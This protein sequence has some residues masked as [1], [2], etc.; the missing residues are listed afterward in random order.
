MGVQAHFPACGEL[1]RIPVLDLGLLTDERRSSSDPYAAKTR[2]AD[3]LESLVGYSLTEFLLHNDVRKLNRCQECREFYVSR[4][5]RPSKFCSPKC[6]LGFHNRK[7]IE[8]GEHREY[9]RKKRERGA[10]PSYYG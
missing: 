7:R 10:K 4:T 8:S 5:V 9:K 1:K 2:F 3:T 6:R